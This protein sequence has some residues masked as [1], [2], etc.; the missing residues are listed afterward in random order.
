M[1]YDSLLIHTKI[2]NN[3]LSSVNSGR[4]PHALLFH[5]ND[6]TGKEAHA[7]E[8]A[9][10]INCESPSDN[11]ACGD[12]P[13]CKKIKSFQHGNVKLI[14]PYPRGKISSADDP[15]IRGLTEKNIEQ[16]REM[17]V[18]KGKNPYARIE[19]ENARTILINSIREV[20]K[21]LYMSSIDKGWTVVLIFDAEKLCIPQPTGAN[22]LLKVL[23]EPPEKTIFILVTSEVSAMMDTIRSRCQQIYFP[24]LASSFIEEKLIQLDLSEDKAK[25][26]SNIAN[27]D[28]RLALNLSENI[29]ELFSDLK[30][31]IKACYSPSPSTWQAVTIRT[32]TLKRKSM[33][34]LS[35]FFRTS[36][37]YMRDLHLATN[38][39]SND[40]FIFT[41]LTDH[42]R[43]VS[44]DYPHANW[45]ECINILENTFEN[46]QRNGYL[47]LMITAMLI[48]LKQ[49]IVGEK[50]KPFSINDWIL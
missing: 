14:L 31:M 38:E 39:S 4:L 29:D 27:G 41:N 46:I 5:G 12:C 43:K 37:L 1:I 22:A 49:Q 17:M 19:I 20:K 33:S 8:L 44:V 24:P 21:D 45:N 26:I 13:S 6:G 36:I 23:E 48:E 34:E 30:L 11:G 10:L 9:A 28:I 2:W 47:P 25:V 32:S 7:I 42:F 15:S 18:E 35:Y 16:L 40:H 50:V 3:L